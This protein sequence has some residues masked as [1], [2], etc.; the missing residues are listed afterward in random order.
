M[1]VPTLYKKRGLPVKAA[2]CAICL[3]RTRG[4]TQLVGMTHG[5]S[6]WLCAV[7]AS[8]EFRSRRGGRDFVVTLQRV[9][10]ASGC[11]TVARRRALEA[12]LGALRGA[13]R[14]RRPG[15]YAWPG[16]RGELERRFAAG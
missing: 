10:H 14:R 15:S 11:L 9:W 12:H 1:Y 4:R 6:V 8:V 3:D 16:V 2:V 13:P 5:V 7:H